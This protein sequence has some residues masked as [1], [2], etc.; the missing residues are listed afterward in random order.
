MEMRECLSIVALIFCAL[1]CA[2]SLCNVFVGRYDRATFYM[3]MAIL[4]EGSLP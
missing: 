3:A 4:L 2:A 1:N